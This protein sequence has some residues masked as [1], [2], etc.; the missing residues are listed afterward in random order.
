MLRRTLR[1]AL[2]SLTRSCVSASEREGEG[3]YVVED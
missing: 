1:R 2:S 3:L